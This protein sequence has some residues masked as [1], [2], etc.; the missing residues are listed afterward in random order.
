MNCFCDCSVD[1]ILNFCS[2]ETG[3]HLGQS[4]SNNTFVFRD[5]IQVQLEN[6]PS[7][8]DVWVGHVDLLVEATRSHSSGIKTRLV[9]CGSDYHDV[10]VLV[11]AIHFSQELVECCPA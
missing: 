10:F 4:L 2:C 11:K 9:I 8:I 1:Q 6:V 3:S 7:T 5:F